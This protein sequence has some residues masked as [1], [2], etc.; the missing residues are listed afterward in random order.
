MI[1][2][3]VTRE[4][5]MSASTFKWSKVLQTLH[6]VD[7][8]RDI[9]NEFYKNYIR[10]IKERVLYKQ[11][12]MVQANIEIRKAVLI[13]TNKYPKAFPKVS[14]LG[15][16]SKQVLADKFIAGELTTCDGYSVGVMV[17]GILDLKSQIATEISIKAEQDLQARLERQKQVEIE[18]KSRI[19]VV[20]G[21][22]FKTKPGLIKAFKDLY[23]KNV[24]LSVIGKELSSHVKAVYGYAGTG[25]KCWLIEEVLTEGGLA[26]LD[27]VIETGAK[28]TN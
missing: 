20:T 25:K 19:P 21:M 5:L 6:N 12:D 1:Y 11:I 13:L 24:P 3:K 22:L 7:N 18:E 28:D 8:W 26:Y 17:Q 2:Y 10:T 9:H 27:D 4:D 16:Y 15:W 14:E 23:T